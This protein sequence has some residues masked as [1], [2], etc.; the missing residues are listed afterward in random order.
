MD[1]IVRAALAYGLVALLVLVGARRSKRPRRVP[2]LAASSFEWLVLALGGAAALAGLWRG[3][4][5]LLELALG[6][7]TLVSLHRLHAWLAH[8]A[9]RLGT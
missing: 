9:L 2:S 8:R 1:A 7:A 4:P 5:S 6:V 3:S